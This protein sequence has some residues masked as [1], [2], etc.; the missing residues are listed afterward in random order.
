[1]AAIP[2]LDA[3]VALAGDGGSPQG[4]LNLQRP[5]P[6]ADLVGAERRGRRRLQ[7]VSDECVGDFTVNSLL[8]ADSAGCYMDTG[9][10]LYMYTSGAVDYVVGSI[11]MYNSADSPSV[12][13]AGEVTSTTTSGGILVDPHCHSEGDITVHA[14]P[15]D[16]ALWLCDIDNTG[17]VYTEM[18]PQQ[19]STECGCPGG[20][21]EAP[22]T[23]APVAPT[24][25]APSAATR[26]LGT[27]GPVAGAPPTPAAAVTATEAPVTEAVTAT[28]A[29]EATEEPPTPAAAAG[30]F[31]PAHPVTSAEKE[32]GEEEEP[33]TTTTTSFTS[34]TP[35][36]LCGEI[37]P[38][39]IV[40]SL[41]HLEALEGCYEETGHEY[42][43]E[44]GHFFSITG[45][46]LRGQLAVFPGYVDAESQDPR[47]FVGFMA[48]TAEETIV[49]CISAQAPTDGHPST[50]DWYCDNG[51]GKFPLRS[52]DEF[53][54]LCGCGIEPPSTTESDSE[55]EVTMAP[56]LGDVTD[57][58]MDP[59]ATDPPTNGGATTPPAGGGATEPPVHRG[60]TIAPSHGGATEH[61]EH[62]VTVTPTSTPVGS[63]PTLAPEA[64]GF[65]PLVGGSEAP[66]AAA[67]GT[68]APLA[69]HDGTSASDHGGSDHTTSA[70]DEDHH[71][72]TDAHSATPSPTTVVARGII[73]ASESPAPT[74]DGFESVA[75]S[76][77]AARTT[78]TI[79][80]LGDVAARIVLAV[81]VAVMCAVAAP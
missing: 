75:A 43:E 71:S 36:G 14:H 17:V 80:G 18:T 28:L 22:P 19:F 52:D 59:A 8:W 29:P 68:E 53:D 26:D 6:L 50:A 79:S 2:S 10:S 77:A 30:T 3:A 67:A 16:V 70:S 63:V 11:P 24:T 57:P 33:P 35:K 38:L 31:A 81:S 4:A 44:G 13:F 60:A 66:V 37:Q 20:A 51:M 76:G 40:T 12:W 45:S 15:A 61:P 55:T 49:Y 21:A 78:T 42:H 58:P 69:G 74:P 5:Q 62:S 27:L 7:A 23:T 34:E 54:I 72:G 9:D 1:M 64:G 47:W 46:H 48:L 41:P 39:T 56:V 65:P 25:P 73:A 32:E